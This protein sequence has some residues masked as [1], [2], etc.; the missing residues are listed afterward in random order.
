M[1]TDYWMAFVGNVLGE[2][3][4]TCASGCTMTGWVYSNS[5]APEGQ[6]DKSIWMT[7]WVGGGNA[8]PN[9]S[10]SS[11]TPMCNGTSPPGCAYFFRHSNYDTVTASVADN[12]TGYSTSLPNSFYLNAAPAYFSAGPSCSY[13]WPWVM[14]TGSSKIQPPTGPGSCSSYTGLPAKA[15]WDAGTPFVQP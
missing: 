8:D 9:L 1:A 6:K 5:G 10:S 3:G 11:G 15:R 2:P 7:G 12:Q 13:T 4:V 14:P